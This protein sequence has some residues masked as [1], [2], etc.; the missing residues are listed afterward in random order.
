MEPGTNH[1]FVPVDWDAP[2]DHEGFLAQTPAEVTVKGMFIK[3]LVDDVA[4]AGVELDRP[5]YR[6]FKDYPLTELM[7][8]ELQAAR[9]L[10]P[11]A[12]TRS[13]LRRFGWDAFP[14][15]MSTMIG[16]VIFAPVG[17]DMAAVIRLATRG[18]RVSLSDCEVRV[19]DTGEDRCVEVH[20]GRIYNFADSYQV[21]VFEGAIR[22]YGYE[23]N[24]TV[25]RRSSSD[26]D[27]L[28]R[29]S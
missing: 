21:G 24:V 11:N 2:L 6:A 22:H 18:Y 28:V 3:S 14:T 4:R 16:R 19:V 26:I 13:A 15:L 20:L 23:P 25:R 29:W 5:R 8:V 12:T 17:R 7:E 1:N 9:L 27:L 10:Y